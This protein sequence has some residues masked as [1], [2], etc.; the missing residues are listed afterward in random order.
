MRDPGWSVCDGHLQDIRVSLISECEVKVSGCCCSVGLRDLQ[1]FYPIRFTRR[2]S[3]CTG[4]S[5]M[6]HRQNPG[7]KIERSFYDLVYGYWKC[8]FVDFLIE[9]T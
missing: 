4:K 8:M 1:L 9:H 7:L 2:Y 6:K 5:T 3:C